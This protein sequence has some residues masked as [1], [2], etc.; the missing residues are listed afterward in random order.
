MRTRISNKKRKYIPTV[1]FILIYTLGRITNLCF[2]IILL[3]ILII[4]NLASLVIIVAL[5]LS[6]L[7]TSGYAYIGDSLLNTS[8][9][10]KVNS[11]TETVN[12]T[13]DTRVDAVYHTSTKPPIITNY[14]PKKEMNTNESYSDYNY[15]GIDEPIY[16]LPGSKIIYSTKVTMAKAN[17]SSSNIACIILFH[18]LI[19]FTDFITYGTHSELNKHRFTAADTIAVLSRSFNITEE[20][21]YYVG[22]TVE[23]GVTVA[24]NVSIIRTYYD[25]SQLTPEHTCIDSL[26]CNIT[27]CSSGNCDESYIIIETKN[28]TYVSYTVEHSRLFTSTVILLTTITIMI[29]TLA[30]I[31][32]ITLCLILNRYKK[33]EALRGSEYSD[34]A[35]LFNI[36]Q[37]LESFP[38]SLSE[39]HQNIP[40]VR[41]TTL[42][43]DHLEDDQSEDYSQYATTNEGCVHIPRHLENDDDL[44][45]PL[46]NRQQLLRSL[47]YNTA[48]SNIETGRSSTQQPTLLGPVAMETIKHATTTTMTNSIDETDFM[49]NDQVVPD[50]HQTTFNYPITCTSRAE[51]TTSRAVYITSRAVYITSRAV[52]ITSRAVD[53]TSRAVDIT[54][55]AV[56]ITSRAEDTML[57]FQ[58]YASGT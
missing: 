25:L 55:K 6:N 58:Q 2:F 26:S 31:V 12:I 27:T 20:S 44:P 16:L 52:Y 41:E 51:D 15:L 33:W 18:N 17:N 54:S 7:S 57:P 11:S 24:S 9:I 53:I 28:S 39:P 49:S 1:I 45:V 38:N 19:K 13:F 42:S 29:A 46:F 48:Q 10:I 37:S 30:I 21:Q 8:G 14:L 35:A 34:T 43:F 36:Q 50:T 3:I 32:L 47:S 40:I 5:S 22:I 23:E 4:A 56:D